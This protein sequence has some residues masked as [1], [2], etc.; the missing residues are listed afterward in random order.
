MSLNCF[1]CWELTLGATYV[2]LSGQLF[3][4]TFGEGV[5]HASTVQDSHAQTTARIK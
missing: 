4:S 5:R 3:V 2:S 1:F